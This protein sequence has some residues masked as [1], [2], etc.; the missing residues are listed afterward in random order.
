MVRGMNGSFEYYKNIHVPGVERK[1]MVA[2]LG[3]IQIV[4]LISAG[5][6]PIQIKEQFRARCLETAMGHRLEISVGLEL[7]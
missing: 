6:D 1:F 5:V 4:L 3:K 2:S 7:V